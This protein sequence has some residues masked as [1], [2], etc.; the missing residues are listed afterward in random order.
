MRCGYHIASWGSQV[1][2]LWRRNKYLL[3]VTH[4]IATLLNYLLTY[5]LTPWSRFLFQKLTAFQLVKKFP[6][7][8]GTQ[9]FTTAFKSARHLSLSWASST[10]SIPHIS[11][12]EDTYYLP[13]KT[14]YSKWSLSFRF[15]NQN[16][17]Y[18]S[19]F[20]HTRY[21]P[22]P[23]HSSR[24]YN[25]HILGEQYRSLSSSLCSFLHSPVTS[26]L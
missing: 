12:S 3:S 11:I 10:Q 21:M 7:F 1:Q 17:V 18:T 20:P 8:Y 22:R 25:P 5:L 2:N 9:K 19:P 24:F 16:P 4:F 23:S 26:F 6:A 15:P 14:G 13:S